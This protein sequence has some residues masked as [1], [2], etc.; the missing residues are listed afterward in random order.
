MANR[1]LPP[2]GTSLW[3]RRRKPHRGIVEGRVVDDP[4]FPDGRALEVSGR[5]YAS[6]SEAASSITGGR[7]NGWIWWRLPD[8]R[9][10]AELDRE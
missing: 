10:V 1:P 3:A 6:L 5:R 7:R 4:S 9:R 8:G 2:A